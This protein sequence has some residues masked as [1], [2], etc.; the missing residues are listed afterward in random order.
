MYCI[1]YCHNIIYMHVTKLSHKLCDVP[2]CIFDKQL[3]H[4]RHAE[5][6]EWS[7]KYVMWSRGISWKL[8]MWHFQF[9]IWLKSS[10]GEV[11]FAESVQWFQG[12][13][14]LKGS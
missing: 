2:I 13:E 9:Y 6:V 7:A 8:K 10:L 3:R 4:T 1:E 11:R 14:Q 12:Y 5:Y